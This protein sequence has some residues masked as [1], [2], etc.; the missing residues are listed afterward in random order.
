MPTV[1]PIKEYKDKLYQDEVN[2][3]FRAINNLEEAIDINVGTSKAQIPSK[4]IKDLDAK[5][6][7]GSAVL[8]DLTVEDLTAKSAISLNGQISLGETGFLAIQNAFGVETI[9]LGLLRFSDDVTPVG[10]YGFQ[11]FDGT[12]INF[13]ADKEGNV[14]LRG[15]I[16]AINDSE[17]TGKTNITSGTITGPLKIGTGVILDGES[18]QILAGDSKI[19]KNGISFTQ[20]TIDLQFLKVDSQGKLTATNVDLAGKF[21]ITDGEININE[22]TIGGINITI[23][24]LSAGT[25]TTPT[26]PFFILGKNG[27]VNI[28]QGY[29]SGEAD[30]SGGSIEG[31]VIIGGELISPGVTLGQQGPIFTNLSANLN[32]GL[33][34]I[35]NGQLTASQVD[36]TGRFNISNGL[37]TGELN[38]GDIVL[39][40][41]NKKIVAGDNEL[42]EDSFIFESGII[43]FGD[44]FK[45][46]S[47]DGILYALNAEIQGKFT[48]EADVEAGTL[49][50]FEISDV[51]LYSPGQETG[52]DYSQFVLDSSGKLS[53]YEDREIYGIGHENKIILNIDYNG[54]FVD[55]GKVSIRTAIDGTKEVIINDSG[56]HA[57]RN[58]TDGIIIA[59]EGIKLKKNGEVASES[60]ISPDGF[61]ARYLEDGSI[62]TNKFSQVKP[63]PVSFIVCE[64]E[65]VQTDSHD[66]A[67][68]IIKWPIVETRVDG[69]LADDIAGYRIYLQGDSYVTSQCVGIVGPEIDSSEEGNKLKIFKVKVKTDTFYSVA[70]VVFDRLGNVSTETITSFYVDKD[71]TKPEDPSFVYATS[72]LGFIKLEWGFSQDI[73]FKYYL[74][75][76][77]QLDSD[78]FYFTNTVS[79]HLIDKDVAIGVNYKYRVCVVDRSGNRSNY[80]ESPWVSPSKQELEDGSVTSEKLAENLFFKGIISIGNGAIL[81]PNVGIVDTTPV[82]PDVTPVGTTPYY[83]YP[84]EYLQILETETLNPKG[85]DAAK[86]FLREG[87]IIVP[88]DVSALTIWNDSATP[89]LK[90][91]KVGL[92]NGVDIVDLK[93][94]VD[95]VDTQIQQ[96]IPQ[97]GGVTPGAD[98]TVGNIFP[99]L[100][101]TGQIG[102]AEKPFAALWADEV[103]TSGN[104]LWIGDTPVLGTD[105]TTIIIRSD[106]GQH[107]KVTSD[108]GVEMVATGL[109]ADVKLQATGAGGRVVMSSDTEIRMTAPQT[110]VS[111]S[112]TVTGDMVV[113][114]DS[115][116]VN[117]ET[118]EVKDNIIVLNKGQVGSGVSAGLAGIK[119]DR[120]DAPD[121]MIVFDEE[122]DMFKVGMA[123]NLETI[124]SQNYVQS[125]L[126]SVVKDA[127]SLGGIPAEEFLNSRIVEEGSNENGWYI[128]WENGLQVCW[129]SVDIGPINIEFGNVYISAAARWD[130]PSL[131]SA[132][133]SVSGIVMRKE[134]SGLAAYISGDGVMNTTHFNFYGTRSSSS[135]DDYIA[136]LLAIGRWK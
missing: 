106:T 56:I 59:G 94:Q 102:S 117:T 37:V 79:N 84:I 132:N 83:Y 134:G 96:I 54:L 6:L 49:A 100:A 25:A 11:V 40:G 86:V 73:D 45:V 89:V 119:V 103:H 66:Y 24:G 130:Y 123:G 57:M 41:K 2:S 135:S 51:S 62:T 5:K 90:N 18:G 13:L 125:Q 69:T 4:N 126:E 28:N 116:V 12:N 36:L 122:E 33:L 82:T 110:V 74:V 114:G 23:A 52:E 115:F 31:T 21:N 76:K 44:N 20:G 97:I 72:G 26:A 64:S 75:E 77:M 80:T 133:P 27:I 60:I 91:L 3:I 53:V 63:N 98:I 68:L 113:N 17:F 87:K 16:V 47:D 92:I 15:K 121:Y 46:S 136:Y 127:D 42:Q 10:I 39:D 14:F 50:G 22:G 129:G 1:F 105:D 67:E 48:G 104:T 55:H 32:N 111:G 43:D 70:I 8:D 108:S 38:I 99:L 120:G 118:V 30:L 71:K 85:I 29:F 78:W 124:A 128:R 58:S 7:F 34:K 9:K 95:N 101:S 19:T 107:I 93:T 35:E 65:I 131:F 61:N 88:P 112:L 109:N 81:V